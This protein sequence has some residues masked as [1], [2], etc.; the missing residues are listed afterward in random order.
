MVV[1]HVSLPVSCTKQSPP[2]PMPRFD[3]ARCLDHTGSNPSVAVAGGSIWEISVEFRLLR[4]A[5]REHEAG[6]ARGRWHSG[7]WR[8]HATPLADVAANGSI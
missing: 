3:G 8:A 1:V 4:F 6:K 7:L 5:R 2:A